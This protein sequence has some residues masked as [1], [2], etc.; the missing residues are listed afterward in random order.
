M[1]SLFDRVA[2][3]IT[4]GTAVAEPPAP[5]VEPE[6]ADSPVAKGSLFD[7]VAETLTAPVAPAPSTQHA[8]G[9]RGDGTR[10][11]PG[12]LGTLQRPDGQISTELSIGVGFDGVETEIPS[13]VP[14]LTKAEVDHLLAGG[15]MTDAIT[16]KA[17]AH[18]RLRMSQGKSPFAQA[19]D[20][21]PV[22]P[23]PSI[24]EQ[25]ENLRAIFAREP[26]TTARVF[27]P[28][29]IPE[30]LR[31]PTGKLQ[32][33]SSE[34]FLGDASEI[35]AE[36]MDPPAQFKRIEGATE[37]E[38]EIR[39]LTIG[40][41]QKAVAEKK[42]IEPR[43][44]QVASDIATAPFM[45]VWSQDVLDRA[46]SL[47]DTKG[48]LPKEFHTAVAREQDIRTLVARLKEQPDWRDRAISFLRPFVEIG[49]IFLGSAGIGVEANKRLIAEAN[50]TSVL[51]LN[52]ILN[53]GG[54]VGKFALE[55]YLVAT[56]S[57]TNAA[58][59]F[60]KASPKVRAILKPAIE[61]AGLFGK[62]EAAKQLF[63]DTSISEKVEAVATQT[64]L[65]ALLGPTGKVPLKYKP[66]TAA[67]LTLAFRES[68]K[69]QGGSEQDVANVT[70]AVLGF[71]LFSIGKEAAFRGTAKGRAA[72][73]SCNVAFLKILGVW[74][75]FA[76]ISGIC[77][78]NGFNRFVLEFSIPF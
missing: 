6:I 26:V 32:V 27:D 15:E 37:E 38:S 5:V 71:Q 9:L 3:E 42:A 78:T 76:Y 60:A 7:R 50:N 4:G 52:N 74:T 44:V 21:R 39:R 2:N 18:A 8:G 69:L 68:V 12:F 41:I 14:T 58:G 48:V 72:F 47:A 20:D 16:D 46:S 64:A 25:T 17:V 55:L 77:N 35:I 56:I 13:L 43:E 66:L 73:H 67:G 23:A 10:K 31:V 54:G 75:L 49:E 34:G 28:L 70:I 57:P 63:Q 61:T 40:A 19:N 24:E 30:K 65:G 59:M 1:A 62:H 36:A 22:T 11:G 51:N 33:L 53:I 29:S 45:S